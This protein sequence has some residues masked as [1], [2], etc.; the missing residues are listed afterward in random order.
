MEVPLPLFPAA[1]NASAGFLFDLDGMVVVAV[2]RRTAGFHFNA[3]GAQAMSL[4][5]VVAQSE[6]HSCRQRMHNIFDAFRTLFLDAA[7]AV[8]D[9]HRRAVGWLI[10]KVTQH[11]AI[12]GFHLMYEPLLQ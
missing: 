1:A 5:D 7:A 2:A 6:P 9:K 10:E 4:N 8:A 12:G 3:G 11:V